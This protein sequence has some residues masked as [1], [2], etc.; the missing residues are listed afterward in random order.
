MTVKSFYHMA[1]EV[2]KVVNGRSY[3]YGVRAERDAETGKYRNRWTY[4]GRVTGGVAATAAKPRPNAREA[5]L[6]ALERLLDRYEPDAITAGAISVEAGVAHGT[7][8]RY[9]KNK[10]EAIHGL[11]ARLR[12]EKAEQFALLDQRPATRDEARTAI[13]LWTA[14]HLRMQTEHPGLIRAWYA[15][16]ASDPEMR[17]AGQLRRTTLANRLGAWLAGVVAAGLAPPMD[18]LQ[19]AA[20]LISTIAGLGRDAAASGEPLDAARLAATESL[21]ERAVFGTL[22]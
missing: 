8:Y 15:L 2:T 6:D 21:V 3:R 19:T 18:P 14:T 17:A 13:R 1:Y 7:F 10:I 22:G 11:A 16:A 9:F 4:L 12:E 20:I 5:L